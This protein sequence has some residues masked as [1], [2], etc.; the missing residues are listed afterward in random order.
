MF[1]RA[2]DAR[3]DNRLDFDQLLA[4]G[5]FVCPGRSRRSCREASELVSIDERL[6]TK[7]SYAI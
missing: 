1:S 6:A 3:D 5:S 4:D 7:D 2:P